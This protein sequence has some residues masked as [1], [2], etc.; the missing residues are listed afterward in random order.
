MARLWAGGEKRP[1]GAPFGR[2]GA[3]FL[4]GCDLA[5][6]TLFC[7]YELPVGILLSVLGAPF[8]LWLLIRGGRMIECRGLTVAIAPR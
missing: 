7:A 8:F 1:G 4:T 3:T 5:A 2:H 6:R